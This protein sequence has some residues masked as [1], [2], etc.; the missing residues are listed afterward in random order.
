M[1]LLPG[2]H[3]GVNMVV[4]VGHH[5]HPGV[6]DLQQDI[7]VGLPQVP[8]ALG[9]HHLGEH[10]LITAPMDLGHHIHGCIR[11][12]V[13]LLLEV[14][15]RA[16]LGFLVLQ[17]HPQATMEFRH[18]QVLFNLAHHQQIHLTMVM[19]ANL[20][21]RAALDGDAVELKTI[22]LEEQELVDPGRGGKKLMMA[23][24]PCPEEA[25]VVNAGRDA[26][27]KEKKSL[28]HH[29]TIIIPVS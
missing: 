27:R 12:E 3:L 20:R 16:L 25:E 24:L 26:T 15:L 5:R 8:Q 1:R 18:R 4:A 2:V 11:V 10:T 13:H 22:Q 23:M 28:Q 17:G 6:M 7:L 14:Q 19:T 29:N 21:A 9:H